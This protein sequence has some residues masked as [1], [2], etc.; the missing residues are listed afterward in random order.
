MCE[1]LTWKGKGVSSFISRDG[2]EEIQFNIRIHID[3]D[4]IVEGEAY[5]DDG[6]ASIAQLYYGEKV[7]F[8]LPEFDARKLI[9]VLVINEDSDNPSLI[10]M[11]GRMLVD[12]FCYGEIFVKRYEEGEGLD[13]D[14]NFATP[15]DEE[16]LPSEIRRALKDSLPIGCFQMTG[17]FVTG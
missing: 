13:I 9:L 1:P 12:R 10:I 7:S 8:E 14:N 15:I 2:T 11:N 16:Y 3:V 17:D 5:T 6:S 4:G